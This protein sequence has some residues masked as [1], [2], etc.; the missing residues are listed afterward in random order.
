MPTTPSEHAGT[1]SVRLTVGGMHCGSCPA[2]IEEARADHEGVSLVSADLDAAQAHIVFDP[3]IVSVD[4]LCAV[5]AEV[6]YS[7]AVCEDPSCP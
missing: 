6:G 1:A 7:A 3:S 4:D 5:I 2:L